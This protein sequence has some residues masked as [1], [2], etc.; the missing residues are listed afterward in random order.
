MYILHIHKE[1]SLYGEESTCQCR[2]CKRGRLDPQVGKIPWS[3]KWQLTPAPDV[4]EHAHMLRVC[5]CV[6]DIYV[7]MEITL[8]LRLIWRKQWH[9]IPVLLHGKS[10]GWRSLIGCSPWGR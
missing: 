10:H 3:R 4:T 6:C 2:R 5:V 7:F 8:S 9:P 1:L